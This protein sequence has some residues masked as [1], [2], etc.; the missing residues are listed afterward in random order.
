MYRI[1][2]LVTLVVNALAAESSESAAA[3]PLLISSSG[4]MMCFLTYCDRTSELAR[5]I[6]DLRCHGGVWQA[7]SC[8][9]AQCG[10]VYVPGVGA[11]ASSEP[12]DILER[13]DV[14]LLIMAS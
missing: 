8:G 13:L 6:A 12:I 4:H 1:C 11:H 10:V 7:I 5:K 3:M 9:A 14:V 2:G